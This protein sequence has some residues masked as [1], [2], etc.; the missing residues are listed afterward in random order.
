MQASETFTSGRGAKGSDKL[1]EA[2]KPAMATKPGRQASKSD[3]S[4]NGHQA[5]VTCHPNNHVEDMRKAARLQGRGVPSSSTKCKSRNSTHGPFPRSRRHW[6]KK[7]TRRDAAKA[8]KH[9]TIRSKSMS[10]HTCDT[11]TNLFPFGLLP[12]MPA[13]GCR[14]LAFHMYVNVTAAGHAIQG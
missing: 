8:S 6:L 14:K 3:K 12:A 5:E 1:K 9:G 7:L 11:H 2:A 10:N 13:L 4:E